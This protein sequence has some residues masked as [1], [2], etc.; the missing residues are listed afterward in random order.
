M[1]VSALSKKDVGGKKPGSLAKFLID[2]LVDTYSKHT[3]KIVSCAW[4]TGRGENGG[5]Q[6]DVYD[7]IVDINDNIL[8]YFNIKLG[9]RKTIGKYICDSIH[10]R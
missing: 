5:Y 10:V 2:M 3:G 9:S 1:M 8:E 4:N 6:G 7:F